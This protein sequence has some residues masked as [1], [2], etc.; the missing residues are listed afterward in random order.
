MVLTGVTF[1]TESV[2][3]PSGRDT[4]LSGIR[5]QDVK[6]SGVTRLT[7]DVQEKETKAWVVSRQRVPE[8]SLCKAVLQYSRNQC[9]M[10]NYSC[11]PSRIPVGFSLTFAETF[12]WE[13]EEE[14]R[15]GGGVGCSISENTKHGIQENNRTKAQSFC[16]LDGIKHS[17][18][19][20]QPPK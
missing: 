14:K 6:M 10:I 18:G 15:L 13:S 20:Q 8:T 12:C 5:L 1:D 19:R 16:W 7:H 11:S 3:A 2:S 17:H 9:L 4:R